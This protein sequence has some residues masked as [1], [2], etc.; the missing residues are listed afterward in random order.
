MLD[1][2]NLG[3]YV[4]PRMRLRMLRDAGTTVVYATFLTRFSVPL[5]PNS[6][7]SLC[8][9]GTDRRSHGSYFSICFRTTPAIVKISADVMTQPKIA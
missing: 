6:L 4:I 3:R 1:V 2:G 9:P 5:I 8:S 7:V